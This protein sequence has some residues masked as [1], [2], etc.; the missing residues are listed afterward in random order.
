M[1]APYIDI[2]ETAQI[3]RT[4]LSKAFPETRFSVRLQ[5]Y[6]MGSHVNISYT[7]GPPAKAVEDITDQFYGRGFDGMTDCTTFHDS[8]YEGKAVHFA[9]SR[10]SVSRKY[11]GERYGSQQRQAIESL[12]RE[13]LDLG[14]WK[15]DFEKQYEYERLAWQILSGWDARWETL[16]RAVNRYFIEKFAS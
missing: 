3:I 10:P 9:G 1:S 8:E 16:E 14:A 2:K 5:R 13:R 11:S 6:S 4:E 15:A 7:D 12:L